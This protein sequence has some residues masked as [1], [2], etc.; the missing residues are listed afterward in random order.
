MFFD[1]PRQAYRTE[2]RLFKLLE[3]G[4][5][6]VVL[7]HA[8]GAANTLCG[9]NASREAQDCFFMTPS[10]P[11]ALAATPRLQ[12]LKPPGWRLKVLKSW[13]TS[14]RNCAAD[15]TNA[16]AGIL[17]RFHGRRSARAGSSPPA[18]ICQ[19][20][21]EHPPKAMRPTRTPARLRVAHS[22]QASWPFGRSAGMRWRPQRQSR[23]RTGADR[24][25]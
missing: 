3:Q 11:P 19:C 20:C 21:W 23:A 4:G 9:I 22:R 24:Q 6:S 13:T 1:G 8:R 5:T 15:T 16:A 12:R 2:C 10:A 17:R 14:S 7:V 25:R 18:S